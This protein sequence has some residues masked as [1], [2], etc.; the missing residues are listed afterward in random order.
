MTYWAMTYWGGTRMRTSW[1]RLR[2]ISEVAGT[3][4]FDLERTILDSK[5]KMAMLA[6]LPLASHE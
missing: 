4:L 3:A 6:A 1:L 2:A 5:A